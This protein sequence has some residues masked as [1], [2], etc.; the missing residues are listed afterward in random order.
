ML[1]KHFKYGI[2]GMIYII[3][4]YWM[5]MQWH[6]HIFCELW[7]QQVYIITLVSIMLPLMMRFG[8]DQTLNADMSSLAHWRRRLA[9]SLQQRCCKYFS[10]YAYQGRMNT[11]YRVLE[12]YNIFWYQTGMVFTNFFGIWC[13]GIMVSGGISEHL[14]PGWYAIW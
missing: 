7:Y 6:Q 12:W 4:R 9:A 1:S 8:H 5:C 10:T 3:K 2:Y 13:R 14:I 11:W